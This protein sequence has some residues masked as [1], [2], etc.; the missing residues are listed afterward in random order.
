MSKAKLPEALRKKIKQ[1]YT[2]RYGKAEVFR[3][4]KTE[5]LLH[6]KTEDELW[7]CL[8]S[9]KGKVENVILPPQPPTAPQAKQFDKS[10]FKSILKGL[11]ENMPGKEVEAVCRDIAKHVLEEH[12]GFVKVVDGPSFRGTPF[13]LFGFKD[14]E[15]YAVELKSSLDHFNHPGET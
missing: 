12:E 15:P 3:L 14:G 8:T 4:V 9:L 2:Q 13:D 11:T 6:L 7:R 10:P 5:R 1:L